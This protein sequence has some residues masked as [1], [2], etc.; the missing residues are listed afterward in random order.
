MYVDKIMR[1]IESKV[2]ASQD[3]VP[4]RSVGYLGQVAI[5]KVPLERGMK[6]A[7]T[8]R[9]TGVALSRAEALELAFDR[10]LVAA[11]AGFERTGEVWLDKHEGVLRAFCV[12]PDVVTA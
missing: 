11:E 3:K 1:D 2:Y 12:S 7:V 10:I 6:D 8:Y 4:V 5:L 9:R